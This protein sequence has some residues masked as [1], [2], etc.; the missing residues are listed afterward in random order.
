[1][2]YTLR[3][4]DSRTYDS[5]YKFIISVPIHCRSKADVAKVLLRNG[6]NPNLAN[7]KGR[8]PLIIAAFQGKTSTIQVFIDEPKTDL[9]FQVY[10]LIL[11]MHAA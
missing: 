9:N 2:Y 4:V 8:T 11:I 10:I 7:L 5:M 6:A 1:M 3:A